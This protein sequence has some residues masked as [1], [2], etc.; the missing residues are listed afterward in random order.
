MEGL[1]LMGLPHQFSSDLLM[2]GSLV[3][4]CNVSC[5]MK[6]CFN[7]R[8]GETKV[9]R[10]ICICT[11]DLVNKGLYYPRFLKKLSQIN[12]YKGDLPGKVCCKYSKYHRIISFILLRFVVP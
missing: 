5:K 3:K 10:N 4:P 11:G 12:F 7:L 8:T 1:L 2:G 6:P 9:E